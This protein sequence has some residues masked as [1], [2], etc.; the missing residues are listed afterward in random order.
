MGSLFIWSKYY[1]LTLFID[2]LNLKNEQNSFKSNTVIIVFLKTISQ[3]LSKFDI[4]LSSH[5]L[6][7]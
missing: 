4:D 1:Y 6:W 2:S 7:E 5:D 3:V